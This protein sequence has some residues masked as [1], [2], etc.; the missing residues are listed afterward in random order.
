MSVTQDT[1]HLR[2]ASDGLGLRLMNGGREPGLEGYRT[3]RTTLAVHSD[4]ESDRLAV[5]MN[6]E[7][8]IEEE[9]IQQ[10]QEIDRDLAALRL[11][12]SNDQ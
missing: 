10:I 2:L 11:L 3:K 4:S 12:R 6:A 9:S 5:L 8:R 7:M 1:T